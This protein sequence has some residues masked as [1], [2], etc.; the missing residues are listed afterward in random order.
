M[1]IFKNDS[2]SQLCRALDR[3]RRHDIV[4][5]VA[6]ARSD[7]KPEESR[8][9]VGYLPPPTAAERG[10]GADGASAATDYGRRRR[11]LSCESE[12]V[13]REERK[14]REGKGREGDLIRRTRVEEGKKG[15]R[16][17]KRKVA[18]TTISSASATTMRIV[19][20]SSGSPA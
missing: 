19:S 14:G 13:R 20:E 7:T 5:T 6:V 9:S 1:P 2:W 10:G 16:K 3:P 8:V 12:R 4:F 11:K 15:G 17:E 18:T